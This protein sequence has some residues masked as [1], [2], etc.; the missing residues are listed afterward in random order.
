MTDVDPGAADTFVLV[1]PDGWIEVPLDPDEL[2]ALVEERAPDRIDPQVLES[3]DWRRSMLQ[4]RRSAEIA[5]GAG[6]VLAVTYHEAV[7]GEDPTD[8]PLLISVLCALTTRRAADIG[9]ERMSF[10]QLVAAV[11][12][13]ATDRSC[14]RLEDP[15]VVQ[16]DHGPAVRDVALRRVSMPGSEPDVEILQ[17][18]YHFLIGAGEGLA[19]L[20]F[21]SPSLA[22]AEELLDLFHAVA[23]TLE[24]VAA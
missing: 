18:R 11:E 9:V 7:G 15:Q 10:D 4:L 22:I 20:A 21:D 8:E 6:V 17:C 2:V 5:A 1:L 19:V 13:Q 3:V 16:F 12:G 24:F 23:S 14:R